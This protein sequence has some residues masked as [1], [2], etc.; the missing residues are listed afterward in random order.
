MTPIVVT[1]QYGK[2]SRGR[3]S[4]RLGD[5]PNKTWASKDVDGNLVIDRPGVW[6]LHC[7]DGFSRESRG[8]IQVNAAGTYVLKASRFS[9]VS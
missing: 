8:A 6:Q 1:S 4:A 2:L 7:S 5:G 9:V 3:H